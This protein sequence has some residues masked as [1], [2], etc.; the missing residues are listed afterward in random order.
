MKYEDF[1]KVTLGLQK[2]ER[3]LQQLYDNGLDLINFVDSYHSIISTLIKSIYGDKGYDWWSWFCWEND[4]GQKGL[5]ASDADGNPIAY[6]FESLWEM[7]EKEY[8]L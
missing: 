2:E 4:F 7:L 8:K 3:R 6:S 1:L 5:E